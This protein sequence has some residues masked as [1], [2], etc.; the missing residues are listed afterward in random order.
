[1]RKELA[2]ELSWYNISERYM[3]LGDG[4]IDKISSRKS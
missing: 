4:T 3:S 2:K 1:M